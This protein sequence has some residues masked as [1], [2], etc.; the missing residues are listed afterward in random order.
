MAHLSG[1]GQKHAFLSPLERETMQCLY[2]GRSHLR[3]GTIS[4]R[5]SPVGGEEKAAVQFSFK[6][7]IFVE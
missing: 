7:L 3:L 5:L 2:N 4:T 1:Q 6:N